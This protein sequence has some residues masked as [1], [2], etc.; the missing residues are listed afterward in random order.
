[1]PP[2]RSVG[3]GTQ[4]GS[5]GAERGHVAAVVLAHQLLVRGVASVPVPGGLGGVPDVQIDLSKGSGK[6]GRAVCETIKKEC[7][8]NKNKSNQ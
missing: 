6:G 4:R 7:T 3:R 5:H 1:M 8:S 2:D